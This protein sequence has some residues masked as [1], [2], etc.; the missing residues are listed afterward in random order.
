MAENEQGQLLKKGWLALQIP[1]IFW[2]ER[3]LEESMWFFTYLVYADSGRSGFQVS[4][5]TLGKEPWLLPHLPSFS[6]PQPKSPQR[7]RNVNQGSVSPV[8]GMGK[9]MFQCPSPSPLYY[10][11]DPWWLQN[12]SYLCLMEMPW[13]LGHVFLM[14]LIKHPAHQRH[15][16]WI[17]SILVIGIRN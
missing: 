7:R 6:T 3:K 9:K 5:C 14:D 4:M 15:F 1:E 8:S 16:I 10:L 11:S 12:V 13:G 2:Q 17:K